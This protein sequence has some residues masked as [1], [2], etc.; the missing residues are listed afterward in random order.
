M[1]NLQLI[2]NLWWSDYYELRKMSGYEYLVHEFKIKLDAIA[3]NIS[4]G[5]SNKNSA[6]IGEW[7]ILK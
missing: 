5:F 6:P 3:P 7:L 2:I 4:W 1:E